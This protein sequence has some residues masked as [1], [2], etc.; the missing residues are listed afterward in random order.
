M[1]ME[2]SVYAGNEKLMNIKGIKKINT[3]ESGTVVHVAK[4]GLYIGYIVISDIIKKEARTAIKELRKQKLD[5]IIM[6]TGDSH[7]IGESVAKELGITDVYT[8]LLPQD[9]V[10]IVEKLINKKSKRSLVFVGDGINDAPSLVRADVG[11]AMG[12]LGADSAVEAADIVIMDDDPVKISTAIK[13]A[14]ST[15]RIVKQNI[16]I[17]I[18]LKI[19]ILLLGGLG[20]ANMWIA[21][22]ADVGVTILTIL[23]SLRI[24]TQ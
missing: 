15:M 8:D 3:K 14:K 20:Y 17:A 12:G 21:V 1:L 2:K 11:I 5:K 7:K 4:G 16:A 6:L 23:N 22:F 9:K 13:I 10:S 18:T 19:L 24:Y